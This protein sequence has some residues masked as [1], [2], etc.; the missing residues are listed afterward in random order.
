MPS[1]Q[2]QLRRK[3]ARNLIFAGHSFFMIA[4]LAILAAPCAAQEAPPAA[5]AVL[6]LDQAVSEAQLNNRQVKIS[7]QNVLFSNDQ[8]LAAR[9]QRY[10]HFNVQLTGS[11]LLTPINIH[12]PEGIFGTV[13]GTPVPVTNSVITTNPK[14]SGMAIAQ[15]YQPL[16]ELYNLHLNIH[17]AESGKELSEEQ[18]R[19]QRQEIT[20]SVKQAY[21]GLLQTQSA[22]EAARENVKALDEMDRTT[23]QYVK[24]GTAL[25]YQESGVKVQLAQAQL[26][27]VT[28]EDT[29][30]TQ[31]E[32]LNDLMGRD[33]ATDFRLCGVPS[34]LPEEQN[35]D[36]ARREALTRRT[37][38]RQA[39]IK[40]DQAV[41]ARRVQKSAYIPDVGVQY[42]FFSP[43]SARGLPTNINSI[44][45][46]VKW[47]VFDWGYKKHLLDEKDRNIEQSHLNLSETRS[48]I[49]VD[50]DNRFRKLREARAS[51]NVAQMTKQA[52]KE[53]LEVVMQEYKQKAALLSTLQA[54][55]A[56]MAQAAAQYQQ[57][58]ANFWTARADFEKALGE[59]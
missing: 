45:I 21:Y 38:I 22:L 47:D 20:D 48:Q 29:L 5:P 57:A 39:A 26:Q 7:Q 49:V 35:L 8:I 37:E 30:Q 33:I 55:Q 25:A 54:E 34:A 59:D 32:N 50:I 17:L 10:P 15:I 6:T 46:S 4:V 40:V 43:F 36:L 24:N 56:S 12:I 42:L 44:G 23:Q 9:T 28:L 14:P 3:E 19:Q 52:E 53:K 58:L 41:L 27:V 51:L 11:Y 13:N 18:L 2:A 16:A 31:K 1:T